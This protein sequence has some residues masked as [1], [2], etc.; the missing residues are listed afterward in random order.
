MKRVLT[1]I[2][3]WTV[4][5]YWR[6]NGDYLSGVT[7]QKFVWYNLLRLP[8]IIVATYLVIYI[9][10]PKYIIAS[11]Q[12]WKFIGLFILNFF[13]A[14]YIDQ[15]I[16]RSELMQDVLA[17]AT[18]KQVKVFS[19]LHPFR[20]S[21]MLL[22]IIGLASLIKFFK[23]FLQAERQRHQLEEAHLE[24]QLAFLQTQVNPHFLFNALNN[25]YSMAVQNNQQEIALGLENL[26]GIMHYLTYESSAKFVPLEKEIALLK[27]Y[28][29]IQQLRVADTDDTTISFNIE[30]SAVGKKVAPVLLLPIL[31]NAFKHGIRPDKSCLVSIK[32]IISADELTFQTINTL[33]TK[34]EKTIDE[35]GIGL[36]NVRQRLALMYPQKHHFEIRKAGKYFHSTLQLTLEEVSQVISIKNDKSIYSRR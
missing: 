1:H 3:F 30:G 14:F 36:A 5:L 2:A 26:S 4:I 17:L 10:L 20:N 19:Q 34:N 11:K 6:A 24:T 31:E 33:F 9:F 35:K 8:P 25:I 15:I 13:V 7:L 29:D 16:I 22:S 21:F 12:Y 18:H 32:L 28:I 23:L 27:N